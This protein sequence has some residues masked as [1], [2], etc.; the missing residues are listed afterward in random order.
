MGWTGL[1]STLPR[2]IWSFLINKT[3][4]QLNAERAARR[5]RYPK[6]K[7]WFKKKFDRDLKAQASSSHAGGPSHKE[8]GSKLKVLTAEEYK[9]LWDKYE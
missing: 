3:F 9:I 1:D 5:A 4:S 8:S 7:N 2:N 6:G